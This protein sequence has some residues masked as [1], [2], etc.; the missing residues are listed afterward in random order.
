MNF[1]SL[2][3]TGGLNL[4]AVKAFQGPAETLDAAVVSAQNQ[5]QHISSPWLIAPISDRLAKL[6]TVLDV[7][8]RRMSLRVNAEH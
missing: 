8:S 1:S 7:G 5:L 6:G 3:C 4:D 2:R